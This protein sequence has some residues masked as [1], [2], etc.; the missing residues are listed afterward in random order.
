MSEFKVETETEAVVRRFGGQTAFAMRLEAMRGKREHK[1]AVS[2]W[3]AEDRFPEDRLPFV[4]AMCMGDGLPITHPQLGALRL[5][6]RRRASA[7]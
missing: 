6:L 5:R 2:R 4:L 7:R 3:V 1:Q